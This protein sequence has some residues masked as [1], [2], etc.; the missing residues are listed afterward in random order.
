MV[1]CAR[2]WRV[3]SA[4]EGHPFTQEELGGPV[5]YCHNARVWD[6]CT[7]GSLIVTAGEDCTCRVWDLEGKQ[8]KMIKEHIGRGVWRCLYDPTSLD[9]SKLLG[10][11]KDMAVDMGTEIDKQTKALDHCQDYIYVLDIRVKGANQRTRRLLGK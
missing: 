9:L 1:L 4:F 10:E 11:L 5:L 2:I 7:F 8:L 3:G 6:Y